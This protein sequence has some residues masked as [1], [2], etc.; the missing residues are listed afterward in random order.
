[1]H[2]DNQDTDDTLQDNDDDRTAFLLFLIQEE[3][4][5]QADNNMACIPMQAS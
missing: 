2:L 1:M 4:D 5:K 3:L